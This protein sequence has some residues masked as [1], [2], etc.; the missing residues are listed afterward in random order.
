MET[1]TD[2]DSLA[3]AALRVARSI[4]ND[5]SGLTGPPDE[6]HQAKTHE[7]V[8]LSIVRGTRG[9]IERIANQINGTYEHGWYDACAV[10]I[11]RLFETLVIEAFEHH[12]LADEIK[13]ARGD[14]IA[15]GDMIDKCLQQGVWNLGRDTRRILPT[16]KSV[17]DKSAHS[18]RF[19]AH[20]SDIEPI[21]ADI[22]TVV[23]ELIFLAGFK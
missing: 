16:L 10:M 3:P 14:F 4:E 17:G 21:R 18:R 22:R 5:L 19:V 7:V 12:K 20:K 9:Y 1:A 13:N 11:R 8:P 15:F 23:Q 6:G 2:P